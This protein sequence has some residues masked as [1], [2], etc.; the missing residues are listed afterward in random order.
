MG[1]FELLLETASNLFGFLKI[2][3][4]K[5][6]QKELADY[7]V[8]YYEEKSKDRPDY[9]RLDNYEFFVRNLVQRVNSEIGGQDSLS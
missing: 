8:M 3:E 5:R 2:K 1:V 4:A 7:R 6:Y 9:A